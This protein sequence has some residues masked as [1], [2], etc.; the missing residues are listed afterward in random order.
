[1]QVYI[2]DY[3]VETFIL[4]ANE[5]PSRGLGMLDA[6]AQSLDLTVA[7][8]DLTIH[9]NPGLLKSNL[10]GGTT[11]AVLWEVTQHF[12]EWMVSPSNPMLKHGVLNSTSTILELGSGI[13]GLIGIVMAPF[14]RRFIFTDQEY[15]L[16][17][18]QKNIDENPAIAPSATK[19]RDKK[20]KTK[21][22]SQ[23]QQPP[24]TNNH[25]EVMALDW[26]VS[27]LQQL[28]QLLGDDEGVDA[29]LAVDCVFNESLVK[30][31][32]QTCKAI[33]SLRDKSDG[34][35]PTVCVFAQ[36][37]RSDQVFELWCATMMQYFTVWRVP[38]DMLPKELGD[39]SGF[40]IHLAVLKG[41]TS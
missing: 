36:Q 29:V 24:R 38:S 5:V 27:S 18:L 11:G 15:V 34:L 28:P 6:R 9:Q 14:I 35:Q 26:E 10:R 37:R 17:M 25:M 2:I 41:V 39:K 40:V 16:K 23:Q 21:T 13:T 8:R 31:L 30:P 4:Y 12:A 7:G 32:V 19:T 20:H 1:M 3:I 22:A 33:C